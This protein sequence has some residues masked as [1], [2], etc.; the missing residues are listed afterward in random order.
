MVAS[1]T[2]TPL[3]VA[4]VLREALLRRGD[5]VGALA[6]R[7]LQDFAQAA[8]GERL[9]RRHDAPPLVA[10]GRE[11]RHDLVLDDPARA[12]E[13]AQRV[14]I[15]E[16]REIGVGG[17]AGVRLLLRGGEQREQ[18]AQE[19]QLRSL[20]R[21]GEPDVEPRRLLCRRDGLREEAVASVGT[22][23][24]EHLCP[25]AVEQSLDLRR[26]PPHRRGAC[27]DLRPDPSSPP[28]DG[29]AKRSST[30]S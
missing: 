18:G 22:G 25:F 19:D 27:D 7:Q 17:G 16:R 12:A 3:R 30:V 6:R 20:S 21:R 13:F 10:V 15:A 29:V 14:E 8:V 23:R 24:R 28:D 4:R 1:A 5:L 11:L 26:G 9:I 2:S